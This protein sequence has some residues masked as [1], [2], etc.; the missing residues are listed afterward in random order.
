MAA[1]IKV[2]H[3]EAQAAGID[4]QRIIFD[5]LLQPLFFKTNDGE[6]IKKNIYIPTKR[7]WVR[8]DEHY[9]V[10]FKIKCKSL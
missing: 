8:H 6:Y 9:H 1:H 7:S 5:P 4:I 3:L 10:D 2:L